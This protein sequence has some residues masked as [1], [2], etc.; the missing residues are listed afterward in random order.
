MRMRKLGCHQSLMF[1]APPDVHRGI[2]ETSPKK[3]QE[4]DSSDV[5][6]W[7]LEQT[8][9]AIDALKPLWLA[10]GLEFRHRHRLLSELL[11]GGVV[12]AFEDP[13]RV[14]RFHSEVQ[15]PEGQTLVEMY[16]AA[17]DTKALRPCLTDETAQEDPTVQ[18]LLSTWN[19]FTPTSSGDYVMQEEQEREISHEVEQE[20]QIQKP[21]PAKPTQHR[22]HPDL[23]TFV[24]TGILP[25]RRKPG[26]RGALNSLKSTSAYP[27]LDADLSSADALLLV[28]G[29][30]AQ[31][32]ELA[33]NFRSDEFL[34]PVKWILSSN[35][36]GR[37]VIIS[38]YEAH[39]LLPE[40]KR[41][42]H[43]RL[44]V[45]S[46]R[47][48]RAMRSFSELK[49]FTVSGS[50]S[51]NALR[52]L[53]IVQLDLFAASLFFQDYQSY[54]MACDFLGLLTKPPNGR[55][56]IRVQSDGFVDGVLRKQLNW[57]V[58]CPFRKSPL[59]FLA[60]LI[61]IRRKGQAYFQTQLGHLVDGRKLTEESF[62]KI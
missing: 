46:A 6:R 57:P 47:T 38:P 37:L 14:Q 8:G 9:L 27:H 59:E 17:A 41:S 45:Y 18:H 23:M 33:G 13:D 50:G 16:G 56:E 21:P 22:L 40:I 20:R 48:S 53:D 49:F 25:K 44:H 32:V 30:F 2:L 61:G 42:Q 31:T 7:C 4:L 43:V 5:V 12:K 24:K 26:F 55:P 3:S 52:T 29:D 28:T 1:F 39:H 34:R 11:E 36:D 10:Q 58:L 60:E 51:E 35:E 19:T 15:E 62:D 54:K